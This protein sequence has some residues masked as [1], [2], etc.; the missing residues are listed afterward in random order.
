LVVSTT[1]KYGP[2]SHQDTKQTPH[3]ESWFLPT[4][5]VLHVPLLNEIIVQQHKSEKES[6]KGEGEPSR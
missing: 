6:R 3:P 4:T 5:G 1:G 2:P